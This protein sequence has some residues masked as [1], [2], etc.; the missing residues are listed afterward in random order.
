MVHKK[1]K[2]E[3]SWFVNSFWVNPEYSIT[4]S[5]CYNWPCIQNEETVDG[6]A[7]HFPERKFTLADCEDIISRNE[8]AFDRFHV[9]AQKQIKYYIIQ[10]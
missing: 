5:K 9:L 3:S 10:S 2:A 6:I 1:P 4:F 8:S 7:S